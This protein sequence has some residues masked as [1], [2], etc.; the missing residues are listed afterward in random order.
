[1]DRMVFHNG[2]IVDAESARVAATL[3]G[4]Q[5]GWGIFTMLR[6]FEGKVFAFE[7]H[8]ARLLKHSEKARVPLLMEKAALTTAIKDLL[9]ANSVTNGRIR[10]TLL[11]GFAGSW[12][13]NQEQESEVLIFTTAEA[14]AT[15]RPRALNLTISPYRLLSSNPLAGVKRTAMLENLLAFEEARSRKFDEAV[16]LNERGEI[17]SATAG[18]IFWVEGNELC[19]PS[20]GTGC[21]A[22][23]TRAFVLEIA[24]RINI[25]VVEGSFPLQRL[26]DANEV[27]LT[28]TARA[29][30]AIKSYD[31][32]TFDDKLASI[33]RNISH[34]FKK[35]T[36]NV[37][38]SF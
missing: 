21:I 7:E 3:A 24:R 31:F 1:M 6:A 17:V 28:S 37:K 33:T 35:L 38:M 32:K 10:V 36:G 30:T 25:H 16:M 29:I 11:K 4:V 9:Q 19:T 2:Q 20:L 27:F 5:Y 22:G 23:I 26:L 13:T 18:N 14:A 12:H 15:T 8:W 34:Q